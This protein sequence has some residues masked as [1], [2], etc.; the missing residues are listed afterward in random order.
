MVEVKILH[1]MIDGNIIHLHNFSM[2][3]T[4]E[5]NFSQETTPMVNC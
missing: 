1:L 3:L 5:G 2:S 4:G